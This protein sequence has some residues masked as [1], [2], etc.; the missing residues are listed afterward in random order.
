MAAVIVPREQ[1][2]IPE[3]LR[4]RLDRPTLRVV[5]TPGAHATAVVPLRVPGTTPRVGAGSSPARVRRARPDGGATRRAAT[6]PAA[7]LV[8]PSP[9]VPA[10]AQR[11]PR[12]RS[13]ATLV[14]VACMAVVALTGIT[15]LATGGP[16]PAATSAAVPAAAPAGATAPVGGVWV[17]QPGDSLWSIAAAVAPGADLRPV[18]DELARR[19]G[20]GN[21]QPG[22]RIP[23]DG[24]AP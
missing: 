20:G 1:L 4:G 9:L 6:R 14:V 12:R 16:V 17:V 10:V 15:A 8:A 24:L 3:H 19:T 13:T 21:L 22:Q 7:P 2:R 18:V 11:R 5:T 23:V